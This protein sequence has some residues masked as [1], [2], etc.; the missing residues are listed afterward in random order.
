M[1]WHKQK[2]NLTGTKPPVPEHKARRVLC[3]VLLH[4][5]LQEV[6]AGS[7]ILSA[8]CHRLHLQKSWQNKQPKLSDILTDQCK[9][10]IPKALSVCTS[11]LRCQRPENIYPLKSYMCYCL[12]QKKVSCS[13]ETD[14][15][16][17]WGKSRHIIE[18]LTICMIWVIHSE[19]Q[20]YEN[21]SI[22]N[23]HTLEVRDNSTGIVYIRYQD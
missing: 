8:W 20:V 11:V 15:S 17:S 4:P 19:L 9:M 14:F 7:L 12:G 3:Y 18:N 23:N 16:E 10:T 5:C 21:K 6:P 13:P 22:F 2:K 1:Q